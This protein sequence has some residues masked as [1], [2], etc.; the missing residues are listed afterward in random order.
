MD[1]LTRKCRLCLDPV[2]R[3]ATQLFHIN[4]GLSYAHQILEMLGIEVMSFTYCLPTTNQL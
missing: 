4:N 1:D 2:S 3:A